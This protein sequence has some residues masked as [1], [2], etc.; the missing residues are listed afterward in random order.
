MQLTN[1]TALPVAWIEAED[2]NWGCDEED[3]EEG[4][5]DMSFAFTTSSGSLKIVQGWGFRLI[6]TKTYLLTSLLLFLTFSGITLPGTSVT[7]TTGRRGSPS[8]RMTPGVW[9][10]RTS[11]R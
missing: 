9:V 3:C 5:V 6:Q 8:W 7:T 11:P 1:E 2:D 10:T 4:E